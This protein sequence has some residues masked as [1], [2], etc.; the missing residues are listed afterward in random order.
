MSIICFSLV[1]IGLFFLVVGYIPA[2]KICQLIQSKSWQI[3]SYLILGFITGYAAVLTTLLHQSQFGPLI[4]I[5]CMVLFFGG[6]FVYVV[7]TNSLKTINQLQQL[8]NAERYNATHDTLTGIPN[9]KHFVETIGALINE[10]QMF[11]LMLFDVVNFKQVNDGMGHHCGDQLL[12]QITSRINQLVTPQDCFARIGGDEFVLLLPGSNDLK[13]AALATQIHNQLANPIE[14]EGY[15]ISAS[16]VIGL[17]RF[18]FDGDSP[19]EML[20]NADLAMYHA[21]HSGQLLSVFDDSMTHDAARQVRISQQLD[22]AINHGGFELYY[23][24]IFNGE[25]LSLE[26][27]EALIRCRTQSGE[28]IA[29]DDFI[30]VAEQSNQITKITS[31]I[32]D[33]VAKDIHHFTKHGIELAVHVNLSAK[34]LLG[35]KLIDQLTSLLKQQPSLNQRLIL[36]ITESVAIN[37]LRQPERLFEK[38]RR[39]GFKI[40]LD[41]FGTGFSS[42]SLL[43]DLP[44]DQIK[45]DRSFIGNIESSHKDYAIVENAITL[46]HGLGYSV[47]AEGITSQE[48]IKMLK[49]MNCDFMQGFYFTKPKTLAAVIPWT[50]SY[51][52]ESLHNH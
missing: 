45:I 28:M 23:Q 44:V 39:L 13:S 31:W 5:L 14:I 15:R 16:V 7:V 29:P 35:S 18:P 19:D 30:A 52:P 24:P 49:Q 22:H 6:I 41:D 47:V 26:G 42:L 12:I 8:A 38:L 4:L 17:S 51:Q 34:D 27:Y 50:Q 43:R 37:R 20:N 3:L 9:R 48:T 2:R 33:Q 11:D 21:K 46:A 10:K 32:L 40:S 1:C 36:E 25:S